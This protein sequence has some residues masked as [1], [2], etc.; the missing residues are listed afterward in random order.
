[1][2][3]GPTKPCPCTSGRPYGECCRPLH[4]GEREPE[5]AEQLVRARYAAFSLGEVDFLYRTLHPDHPDRVRHRPEEILA[6]LRAA[7]SSFK[8]MGLVILDQGE[9]EG[10]PVVLYLAKIFRRG[11][12]VSFIE[13]AEFRSDGTG[14]RYFAGRTVEAKDVAD[15]KSLSLATFG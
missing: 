14:L 6:T 15:P 13:R 9:R 12:D 10:L 8:Y 2:T 7:S 4:R 3:L 5:V 1:V 11:T